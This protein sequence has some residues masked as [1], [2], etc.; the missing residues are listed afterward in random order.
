MFCSKCGANIPDGT[1]FCPKCGNKC[2][3]PSGARMIK[4]KCKNCNG[5][6]EVDADKGEYICPY[7]GDKEKIVDSDA[8]QIE[9][10]KSNTYK[11]MEYARMANENEREARNEKKEEQ[12]AYRKSKF[13]KV[14]VIFVFICLIAMISSFSAGHILS[15]II[16]LIQTGLFAV[17]WLMGMQIIKEKKKF[18][19]MAL[20]I[21]AF[22]LI[23]PFGASHRG[24][25]S[26]HSSSDRKLIWPEDGIAVYLPKPETEYGYVMTND[27]DTFYASIDKIT[28][29]VY[30]NYIDSCKKK[31]FDK[32][33]ATTSTSYEADNEDG[34]HLKLS[35]YTS[36]DMNIDLIS[37][38]KV[39]ENEESAE[40]QNTDVTEEISETEDADDSE[41]MDTEEF[42]EEDTDNVTEE[43]DM[44]EESDSESANTGVVDS[45][46]KAFLDSYEAF[47]D[48]YIEFMEKYDNSD[49]TVSMLA[50][51]T[52][53]MSKYADFAQK[54]DAYD[55][56]SMST[57]DAAYYLEVTTRCAA[58]LAKASL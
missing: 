54:L 2:E 38:D 42:T 19:Y 6:L 52:D 33:S 8:V 50:D 37:P 44:T 40:K 23:V 58:K 13:S 55:S 45:D 16:A 28:D 35:H 31:G 41:T 48:K 7:C 30:S 11:E 32:N 53:Y 5:D 1:A 10:V 43:A 4:L 9:K 21:L 56:D 12:K 51:Y 18:I 57:A 3:T 24:K 47:I 39:K 46:L 14:T 20:A 17:S 22:V 29:D 15:G 49:D 26:T 34:Y 36:D 25:S 27:K